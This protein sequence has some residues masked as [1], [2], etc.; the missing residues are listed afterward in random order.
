MFVVYTTY[1]VLASRHIQ[2]LIEFNSLMTCL[3]LFYPYMCQFNFTQLSLNFDF[4]FTALLYTSKPDIDLL[5]CVIFSLFYDLGCKIWIIFC[6]ILNFT[7]Q[8]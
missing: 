4:L 1:E 7:L 6:I 5:I 8:L 3:G 2:E